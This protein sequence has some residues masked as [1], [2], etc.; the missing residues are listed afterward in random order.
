MTLGRQAMEHAQDLM[1]EAACETA[2]QVVD[3]LRW[4]REDHRA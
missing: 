3:L 2:A 4:D 1:A